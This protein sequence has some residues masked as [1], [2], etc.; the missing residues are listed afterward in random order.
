MKPGLLRNAK[1]VSKAGYRY[2]SI[3]FAQKGKG[4]EGSEK[5]A[6]FSDLRQMKKLFGLDKT[7]KFSSGAPVLGKAAVIS[8]DSL[9]AWSV[10]GPSIEP[11][12]VGQ[13]PWSPNLAGVV[14][15]QFK[16]PGGSVKSHYMTFR[17]VSERPDLKGKFLHPGF[18]GVHLFPRLE[19]WI[20][21]QLG[22]KVDEALRE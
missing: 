18:D 6:M 19:E 21:T 1:K 8:R 12:R 2:R 5:R 11:R 10:K 16:T 17:T 3:P 14:K 22:K 20:M 4:K 7:T 13:M 9:G 15:Y